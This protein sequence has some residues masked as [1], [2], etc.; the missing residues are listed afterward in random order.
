MTSEAREYAKALA[1]YRKALDRLKR[2]NAALAASKAKP[3]P[4]EY[5]LAEIDTFFPPIGHTIVWPS[6]TGDDHE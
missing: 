5:T 4:R 6:Y 1:A 2:A 3:A